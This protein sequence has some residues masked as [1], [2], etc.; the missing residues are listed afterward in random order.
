[1]R[2]RFLFPLAVF[3]FIQCSSLHERKIRDIYAAGRN[4]DYAAFRR[5][6][7]TGD[8]EIYESFKN[9]SQKTNTLKLREPGR[10]EGAYLAGKV[11]CAYGF[12]S[13]KPFFDMRFLSFDDAFTYAFLFRYNARGEA[14]ILGIR[15][16]GSKGL[17]AGFEAVSSA[18]RSSANVYADCEALN[19]E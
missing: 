12:L 15:W 13:Q 10:K 7:A 3:L 11:Y 6:L 4:D 9:V 1:M 16:G 5:N 14:E 17:G 2:A 19:A 8:I 18:R